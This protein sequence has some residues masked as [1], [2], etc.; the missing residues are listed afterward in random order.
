M[1]NNDGNPTFV[2]VVDLTKLLNTSIVKRTTAHVCDPT[3]DLVAAGVVSFVA[4]P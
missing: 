1:A 3:V 4:V 2:A